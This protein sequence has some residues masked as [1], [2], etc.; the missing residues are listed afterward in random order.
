MINLLLDVDT[1]ID[2]ALA[3]FYLAD[4]QKQGQ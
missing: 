1:G 3:L 2:D 4:A